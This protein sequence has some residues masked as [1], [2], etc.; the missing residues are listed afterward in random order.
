MQDL[1]QIAPLLG[2]TVKPLNLLTPEERRQMVVNLHD[3][4]NNRV[5]F[6][7]RAR[8]RK[9]EGQD[10]AAAESHKSETFNEFDV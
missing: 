5:E 6:N 10:Q 4:R 8:A 3:L 9:T 7:K 2:L 1:F